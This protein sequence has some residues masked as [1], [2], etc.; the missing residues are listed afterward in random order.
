MLLMIYTCSLI[1]YLRWSGVFSPMS[2]AAGQNIG[3]GN[4]NN[5]YGIVNGIGNVSPSSAFLTIP[6]AACSHAQVSVS[7][8]LVG[9]KSAVGFLQDVKAST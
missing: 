8:P 1:I 3:N 4:G 9:R 6:C 7:K 2:G 5:N